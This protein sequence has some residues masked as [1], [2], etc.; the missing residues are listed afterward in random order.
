M[1]VKILLVWASE[2][3][4]IVWEQF[5]QRP[6]FASTFKL[7]LCNS[8]KLVDS[9]KIRVSDEIWTHDPPWSSRMLYHWATGDSVAS[10][11]PTPSL[12]VGY[13]NEVQLKPCRFRKS[14]ELQI[15]LL[16]GYFKKTNALLVNF[17]CFHETV[18]NKWCFHESVRQTEN[19]LERGFV[20]HWLNPV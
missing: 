4:S 6:N 14:L 11:G 5:E 3:S 10:K 20:K 8:R 15:T 17:I 2:H 18:H 16:V 7:I 9:E 19:G 13:L 1:R 12:R